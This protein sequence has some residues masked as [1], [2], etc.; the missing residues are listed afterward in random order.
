M[1]EAG[2]MT[3]QTLQQYKE[4]AADKDKASLLA[5]D[6]TV[7]QF[8]AYVLEDRDDQIVGV[9]LE[10]LLLLCEAESSRRQLQQTYGLV[11]ALEC[12][13]MRDCPAAVL[14]QTEAALAHLR[15]PEPGQQDRQAARHR[16][17]PPSR[18]SKVVTLHVTGLV[19][20]EDRDALEAA[21]VRVRGLVSIV[22]DMGRGR[23]TC[24][25]REHV[26]VAALGGAV[27]N[28]ENMAAYHVVRRITADGEEEQLV[29]V[30]E[31]AR[32]SEQARPEPPPEYL[33]EDDPDV[34]PGD[35]AVATGDFFKSATGWLSSAS[36]YLS[37]AFYW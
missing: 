25:V 28:T 36:S 13:R 3:L 34:T 32:A 5:K 7:V 18:R 14:S 9:A 6:S 4:L 15:R 1:S 26:S 10:T 11:Q 12:L 2:N 30:S 21:L 17:R 35:G 37:S 16:P 24:R 27:D 19:T 23:C 29:A 8:L 22:Y 33:P 20:P 31:R